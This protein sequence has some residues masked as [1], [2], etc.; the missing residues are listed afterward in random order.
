MLSVYGKSADTFIYRDVKNSQIVLFA[1]SLAFLPPVALWI[2][3]IIVGLVSRAARRVVHAVFLVVLVA[4][5]AVQ[6]VKHFVTPAVLVV[7]LA[8]AVV[9]AVCAALRQDGRRALVAFVRVS[10]PDPVRRVVR[11]QLVGHPARL[12][13]RACAPVT[14]GSV[15]SAPSVVM[16]TF[17][18]WP[19][20]S[21]VGADGRD[22]SRP[23][24]QPLGVR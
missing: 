23:V 12:S 14:L 1:L 8:A 24:P 11:L 19:T 3:E 6:L 18:E 2:V 9:A 16:I 10:R 4:L 20:D 22:R 7:V 17:D 21:F 15:A 5:F 13:R